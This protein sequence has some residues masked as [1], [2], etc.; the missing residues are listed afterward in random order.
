MTTA[1]T[2]AVEKAMTSDKVIN[3]TFNFLFLCAPNPLSLDIV[4]N[5]LLNV[6]EETEDKEMIGMRIQ[7]CSL[8]LLEEEG[9]GVHI[10][11]HQLVHDVIN[12]VVQ[13]YPMIQ[14]L[15]ATRSFYQF[16][17]MQCFPR[18]FQNLGRVSQYHC[19]FYTAMK[20]FTVALE[21]VKRSK[22]FSGLDEANAN[23]YMGIVHQ[24]LGDSL[25]AREYY[26]REL[27]IRRKNQGRNHVDVAV[28]YGNLGN[29]HLDLGELK[30]AKGH[31]GQA[32]GIIMEKLG[33]NHIHAESTYNNLGKV[34]LGLGNLKQAKE[35]YCRA[36]TIRLGE[37]GL[38]HVHVAATYGSLGN[39][40]RKL[41]KLE[42]AK[43]CY[44]C[45]LAIRLKKL[46][47]EHVDVATT[48]NNLGIVHLM[49]GVPE[50]AKEGFDHRHKSQKARIEACSRRSH[51]H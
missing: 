10:R 6:D 49:S 45:A 21:L 36:L 4:I 3:H 8:L 51:L 38:E 16:I 5:Y 12:A 41:D 20:Y 15:E 44:N 9:T 1:T 19:E 7:R 2:L 47:P 27:A 32:L 43:E 35:Y 37:L 22:L 13:D 18:I 14:Q 29:V 11:V 26:E 28:T 17:G 48:Y 46:G 42:E 40:Y 24:D 23:F 34:H 31:Y 25:Q 50:Q 30:R 39:V 33:P